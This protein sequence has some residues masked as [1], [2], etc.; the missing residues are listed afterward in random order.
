[1][2]DLKKA[3][4]QPRAILSIAA[5]LRLERI[6]EAASFEMAHGLTKL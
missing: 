6:P 4:D 5:Q 1:M 3:G 2:R